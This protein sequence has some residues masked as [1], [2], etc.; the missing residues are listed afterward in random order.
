[1]QL[2]PRAILR[3]LTHRDPDF[4]HG[5]RWYY[6]MGRRVWFHE[7]FEFL[8]TSKRVKNGPTLREFM[9][10]SLH[11]QEDAHSKKRKVSIQRIQMPIAIQ[12]S[13]DSDTSASQT[14]APCLPSDAPYS[15]VNPQ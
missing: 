10:K 9:G 11:E 15:A 7:L 8:F 6:K 13:S 3:V 1:M 2:R 5:M 14:I 4:L 12:P